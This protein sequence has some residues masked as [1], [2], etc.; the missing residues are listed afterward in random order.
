MSAPQA[1]WDTAVPLN[2]GKA[3]GG[4]SAPASTHQ[5]ARTVAFKY[6]SVRWLGV[7]A[8]FQSHWST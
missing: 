8:F 7:I 5:I 1:G 2:T 4:L 6:S 3:F